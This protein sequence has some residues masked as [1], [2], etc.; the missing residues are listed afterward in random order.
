VWQNFFK[1][2][3]SIGPDFVKLCFIRKWDVKDV[4]V[5][6]DSLDFEDVSSIKRRMEVVCIGILVFCC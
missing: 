2:M 1:D 5:M 4:C 3:G 6:I